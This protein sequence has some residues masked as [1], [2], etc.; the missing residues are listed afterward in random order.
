MAIVSIQ[1]E[2]RFLG[3]MRTKFGVRTDAELVTLGLTILGWVG[4]NCDRGRPTIS[5]NEEG[6]DAE[7]LAEKSVL[8]A[9]E[10]GKKRLKK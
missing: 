2:D 4:E 8:L 1:A 9:L 3:E 6:N 5:C 10:N 7:R